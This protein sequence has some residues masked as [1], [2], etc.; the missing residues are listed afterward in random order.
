LRLSS[1]LRRLDLKTLGA[2]N[3][4]LR[5]SLQK[6][7]EGTQARLRKQYEAIESGLVGVADG[8]SGSVSSKRSGSSSRSGWTN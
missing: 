6:Q 7:L 1:H 2:R 4:N 8:A 5:K 3:D